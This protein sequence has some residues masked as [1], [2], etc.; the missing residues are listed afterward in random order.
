M[1]AQENIRN[2]A[3]IAHID[4]GKS[5]F[6]DRLIQKCGGLTEREM[7]TQTR[8]QAADRP[9]DP[10]TGRAV[11]RPTDRPIRPIRRNRSTAIHFVRS[12]P[13][14]PPLDPTCRSRPSRSS[15][16]IRSETTRPTLISSSDTSH[17]RPALRLSNP[18]HLI[19]PKAI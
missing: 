15:H 4:H 10:C 11:R 8:T 17:R 9:I 16:P 14:D 7:T 1:S 6:A 2:F 13:T 19:R 12:D 5:T 3:I 18:T